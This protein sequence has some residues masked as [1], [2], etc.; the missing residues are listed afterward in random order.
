[1]VHMGCLQTH[2]KETVVSVTTA[3]APQDPVSRGAVLGAALP[4]PVAC[5]CAVVPLL[6]GEEDA[7]PQAQGLAC[8][9][10][11]AGLWSVAEMFLSSYAC[12]SAALLPELQ[13]NCVSPGGHVT[14][15]TGAHH[16]TSSSFR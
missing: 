16:G 7:R 3:K 14:H 9:Q 13:T 15:V 11:R 10:V 8:H 6:Q 5:V 1:M 4:F 2:Q 12:L